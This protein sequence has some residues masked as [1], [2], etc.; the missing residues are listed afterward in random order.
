[1][2]GPQAA[3]EDDVPQG[4]TYNPVLEALAAL[5]ALATLDDKVHLEKDERIM[6]HAAQA[7]GWSLLASVTGGASIDLKPKGEGEE[8]AR[9]SALED[10]AKAAFGG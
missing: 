5:E 9:P 8:G 4:A 7:I 10:Q 1:M 2:A 3:P 6:V